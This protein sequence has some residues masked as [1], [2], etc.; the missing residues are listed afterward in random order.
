LTYAAE[1]RAFSA[2]L[3]RIK[4]SFRA[5]RHRNLRLFFAGQGISLVGTWMQQVAMAWL[6][7]RL[8]NSE[9]LL[10]VIA[11]A[12]QFPGL[13]MAPFAGVLADRWSRYRMVV[14]AQ[15]LLMLQA[16]ILAALVVSGR[17]EVWHLIAL[18][19]VAGLVNGADI[20]ARQSLLV[21]LVGG[22]AD[23]PNA[24]ALNS[25]MF[26]GARLV[27]PALGGILIGWVGEGPVF[28]LNAASYVAVLAALAAIRLPTEVSESSGAVLRHIR[29]GFAYAFGHT[30]TRDMLIV[31]AVISLVGVPYV[32]LLPAFARDVLGGDARTLGLLTSSAGLGAF[33][34][35]LRLAARDSLRGIGPL[36]L[37]ATAAFG[38][39]LVA[40]SASRALWLSCALL[41][42]SGFGLMIATAGINTVIQT[43]VS[44][45]M[46]GRVMSLY[47]MAFVGVTPLGS[48][49]GGALA[50]RWGA[51]LTVA[52]GGLGCV[53]LAGSF[54]RRIASLGASEPSARRRSGVL[55][56]VA[57]G[58]QTASELRPRT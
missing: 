57:S 51:P 9:L 25:S 15:T 19:V 46:R 52:L 37:K 31:F 18:A 2:M 23:L 17:V 24:I 30:H 10:G 50:T 12:G 1:F 36:V 42:V 43:L 28:I 32:V 58:L 47:A 4:N 41:V 55:P 21:K 34:G 16:S 5:L 13:F 45:R 49:A 11:F 48:L 26:N 53:A 6:V 3:S 22:T 44:E 7:Y 27:G 56:E 35:A 54:G 14:V 29:D 33:A 38:V 40:F 8:T 20:P 39:A